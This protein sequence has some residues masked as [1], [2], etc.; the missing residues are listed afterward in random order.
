MSYQIKYNVKSNL[1]RF[2]VT[3]EIETLVINIS[4]KKCP[5]P[6]EYSDKVYQVFKELGSVLLKLLPKLE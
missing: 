5:E 2:T 1:S 4:T 6:E 3:N